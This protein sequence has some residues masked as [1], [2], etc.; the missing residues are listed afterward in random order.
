MWIYYVLF[1][2]QLLDI[3]AVSTF[4]LLW[5]VLL[6]TFLYKICFRNVIHSFIH[7]LREGKGWTQTG[8]EHR[9]ERETHGLVVSQ[10]HRHLQGAEPETQERV[11]TRNWSGDLSLCRTM[12]NQ[13]SHVGQGQNCFLSWENIHNR[14][15]AIFSTF[16]YCRIFYSIY[17]IIW[18][19]L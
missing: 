12:F 17:K 18:L 2:H 14:K 4:W 6:W 11:L 3:W 8:R 15:F 13:P 7:Y 9:C 10:S 16:S 5:R 19:N 1:I